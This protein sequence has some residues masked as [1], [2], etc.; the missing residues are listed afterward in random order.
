MS[1]A[2][3]RPSEQIREL[4]TVGPCDLTSR[5]MRALR[6]ITEHDDCIRLERMEEAILVPLTTHTAVCSTA[7]ITK[8]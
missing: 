7:L 8:P 3:S 5:F 2:R 4:A 1:M 6:P